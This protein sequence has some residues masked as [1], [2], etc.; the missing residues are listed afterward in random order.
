MDN[1]TTNPAHTNRDRRHDFVLLFEVRDGNPNGDPDAGNLPRVD[2]ETMQGLVTDVAIK[3]KVRD[4]V[5]LNRTDENGKP[6][7]GYDIYVQH[8]GILANQQRRGFIAEAEDKPT[9]R[10]NDTVRQWMCKTFYDVRMFGA[11]MTT[12]KSGKKKGN[13]ELQWNA[14]QV[15]GAVQLTFA[16]S[17]D[18]IFQLDMTIA[19]VALTN[20]DD[21]KRGKA[22]GEDQEQASSGTFG[23]KAIVPYGLYVAYGFFNPHFAERWEVQAA[24]LELFW[25]ALQRMWEHDRSA[26]RGL[27]ACRGLYIFTHESKLGNAPS[28]KLFERIKV[29]KVNEDVIPRSFSDYN[30]DINRD[31]LPTGVSL[32]VLGD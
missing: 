23:R 3:R 31:G 17:C 22:A 25:E 27:M 11:V 7:Q 6:Q 4:Y 29:S 8:Q 12:G 10:V 24:D 20:A 9:D 30:V 13:T 16:R 1:Q 15:R 32:T 28:H 5:A 19:R 18:P 14:G 21:T 26:A 2:P